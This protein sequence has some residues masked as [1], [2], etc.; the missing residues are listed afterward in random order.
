MKNIVFLHLESVSKLILQMNHELFPNIRGFQEK[1]LC[2]NN[3]YATATSTAMVLNDI[4][5]SDFYRLENTKLFGEFIETHKD[6]TSFVDVLADKGYRTLG[7]HYP[8]ALGNEINPGHMYAQQS[9][10]VNYNN[11]QKAID[12]VAGVMDSALAANEPF[13]IYFCN[14]VSHL[15][16]TDNRKF[17]IRNSTERWE[18]GY[19]TIDATVG[20]IL[21][22]LQ[23]RN[24]MKDTIVFLYG[25]HGDDFYC[26]DYNG[27]FAHSIEPY[28]N[29]IHTPFMIYDE[30]IGAGEIDDI[31]CSLDMKQLVYNLAEVGIEEENTYIYDKYHCKREYV[32]SR[33][34]FAGQIPE[35][36]NGYISNVRKSYAITTKD[37]SLIL[38]N[39]GLRMYLKKLDPTCNNNILDF[40]YLTD[41]KIRH[42]GELDY[43]CVHYKSYMGHG[44]VDE[45]CKTY[46]R[47]KKI[48]IDE[49]ERL[50]KETLIKGVIYYGGYNKIFYTKNMKAEFARLKIKFLKK[51]L[52]NKW[53]KINRS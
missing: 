37:Y 46:K 35:N 7:I 42:I 3:Y 38:T 9:D 16:Y 13:L 19:A 48:M 34:L 5:Y 23:D 39:E 53:G 12:D 15:C 51:K 52:R 25:D 14:E 47:M 28:D 27:G 2:Y 11:Y 18:Y 40:F 31:V 30:K 49:M 21:N 29:I 8:A 50:E 24:I 41:N 10:L 22:L 36:I 26:H 33:N 32:F 4:T 1:C 44:S 20:D 45:I 43:L 17:Y 6:A